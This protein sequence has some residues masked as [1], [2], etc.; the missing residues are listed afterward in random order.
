MS[1]VTQSAAQSA[2]QLFGSITTAANAVTTCI[3]AAGNAFEVLNIKSSD[4]LADNQLKSK[5]M[6]EDRKV[7]V[8]DE[9]SFSIAHRMVERNKLLAQSPELKTA[10]EAALKK[11]EAA[12][13]A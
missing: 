10:Y 4:W 12:I 6:A 1:R 7:A 9:V 11:V 13:A 3:N 5:A 8:I 2:T